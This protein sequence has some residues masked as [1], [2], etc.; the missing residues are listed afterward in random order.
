ML[1]A[2]KLNVYNGHLISKSIFILTTPHRQAEVEDCQHN[3]SHHK[4]SQE[5]PAV[6][7]Y[8][9]YKATDTNNLQ[10]CGEYTP[11]H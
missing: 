9:K 11:S 3:Q 7:L 8:S 4:V 6:P 10:N 1:K 5:H 2:H